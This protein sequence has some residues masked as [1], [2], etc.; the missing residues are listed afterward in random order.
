MYTGGCL[1]GGVQYEIFGE[2]GSIQVCHCQQCRKAQGT[3]F[4]TN[5][6]V[7]SE[8]FNIIQ[9]TELL[10]EFESPT[11]QGKFRV[12]CSNCGSP[13]ISRLASLPEYVRVRAGSINEAIP[14]GIAFHAFVAHKAN[15]W[16]ITDD[17]PQ[18]NEFAPG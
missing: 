2:L 12:F 10:K 18:H 11:T 6:P 9:G 7:K 13:I 16:P 1:C 5:I 17:L 4:A 14:S 3:A 8:N 15:W